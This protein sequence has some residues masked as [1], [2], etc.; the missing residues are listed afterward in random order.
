LL[1]VAFLDW[2]MSTKART[3]PSRFV[4]PELPPSVRSKI[5]QT[6]ARNSAQV[7]DNEVAPYRATDLTIY[8]NA[9]DKI[10]SAQL[11]ERIRGERF[12]TRSFSAQHTGWNFASPADILAEAEKGLVTSR[13]FG[14]V[15]TRH[16]LKGDWLELEKLISVLSDLDLMKGCFVTILKDNVTMPPFL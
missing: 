15:L 5:G 3:I 16:M 12:G 14:I 6:P 1:T 10:W 8:Y 7:I 13:F 2:G 4:V 11:A 9:A